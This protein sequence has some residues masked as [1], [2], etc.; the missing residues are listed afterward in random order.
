MKAIFGKLSIGCFVL[1]VI[2]FVA[3]VCLINIMEMHA[4]ALTQAAGASVHYSVCIGPSSLS[5]FWFF[6]MPLGLILSIFGKLIK[7]VPQKYAT[8]GL[9][10]NA[11]PFLLYLCFLLFREM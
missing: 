10:L 6:M 8:I 9:Y 3:D 1:S 4:R 5:P 11:V 2:A 7:E